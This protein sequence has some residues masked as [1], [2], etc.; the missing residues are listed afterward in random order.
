MTINRHLC[1]GCLT[2]FGLYSELQKQCRVWVVPVFSLLN[3]FLV[4]LL[5]RKVYPDSKQAQ[6]LSPLIL[7][8]FL[9]W[10]LYSGMIMFDLILT[11][12]YLLAILSLWKYSESNRPVW[13]WFTGTAIGFALL[14]KGPV[15]FVHFLPFVMLVRIWHPSPSNINKAFFKAVLW[16]VLISV[17]IILMWAIPAAISGGEEYARAIFWGQSVDRMQ[18]SLL[19]QDHSIGTCFYFLLFY[20]HGCS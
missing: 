15:I 6:V 8:S 1:S 2:S 5:A 10:F 13:I 7:F 17:A 16:A 3:L 14:T 9:G 19:M 12:F 20:F 11:V 18:N 4:N